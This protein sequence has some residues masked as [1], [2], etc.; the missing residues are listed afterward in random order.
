M[1]G[2]NSAFGGGGEGRDEAGER[3]VTSIDGERCRAVEDGVLGE[4]ES[5]GAGG[6]LEW[7]KHI[8]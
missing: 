7:G 6:I 3:E 8:F 5:S 2:G 1:T 4:G